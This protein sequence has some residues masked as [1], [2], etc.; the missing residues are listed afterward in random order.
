MIKRTTAAPLRPRKVSKSRAHRSSRYAPATVTDGSYA[1]PSRTAG[2][3][4]FSWTVSVTY[5]DGSSGPAWMPW[6]DLWDEYRPYPCAPS[7][8]PRVASAQVERP[9]RPGGPLACRTARRTA[10]HRLADG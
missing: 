4:V 8:H 10:R 5:C 6:D 3:R 1:E 2:R 7:V 9:G